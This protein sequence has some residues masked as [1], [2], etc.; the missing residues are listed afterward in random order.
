M[1]IKIA[2]KKL[3]EYGEIYS[4]KKLSYIN[5]SAFTNNHI[6]VFSLDQVELISENDLDDLIL[7]HKE[8]LKINLRKEV[9]NSILFKIISTT[10][11]VLNE[12]IYHIAVVEDGYGKIKKGF[13]EKKIIFLINKRIPIYFNIIGLNYSSRYDINIEVISENDFTRLME[14]QIEKLQYEMKEINYRKMMLSNIM[15]YTSH[16]TSLNAMKNKKSIDNC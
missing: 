7:K 6:K 14:R 5:V 1:K 2:D 11:E 12:E 16:N 4:I 9:P 3:Q 15:S 10:K 8:L 13:Y